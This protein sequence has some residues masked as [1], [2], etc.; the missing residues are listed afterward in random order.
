MAVHVQ[1]RSCGAWGITNNH[2]FPDGAAVCISEAGDPPGSP[3]GSCCAEHE[4][5]EHH[6][7]QAELTGNSTCRP[8][9][10]TIMGAPHGIPGGGVSLRGS[11]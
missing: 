11:A 6:L 8:V 3:E 9:I 2:A 1:C 5:L 7:E 4:S 10:I